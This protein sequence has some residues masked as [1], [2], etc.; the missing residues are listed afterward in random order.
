MI[1]KKL[2]NLLF[3]EEKYNGKIFLNFYSKNKKNNS[4]N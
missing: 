3:P 4:I 2:K 1:I